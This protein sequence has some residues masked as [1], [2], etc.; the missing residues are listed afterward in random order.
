MIKWIFLQPHWIQTKTL[1]NDETVI[2]RAKQRWADIHHHVDGCRIVLAWLRLGKPFQNCLFASTSDPNHTGVC[3]GR[4]WFGNQVC[5]DLLGSSSCY[6]GDVLPWWIGLSTRLIF[7][8]IFPAFLH[9]IFS[10][11]HKTFDWQVIPNTFSFS[12]S[13]YLV[14]GFLK[15][16][17]IP[18]F[19]CFGYSKQFWNCAQCEI[20]LLKDMSQITLLF[21]WG[22]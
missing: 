7:F 21:S 17:L 5:T 4:T 9:A 10:W 11:S 8:I 1:R 13:S 15:R 22:G 16:T 19:I 14:K 18:Y 20:F 12:F 2:Y 6:F 3:P